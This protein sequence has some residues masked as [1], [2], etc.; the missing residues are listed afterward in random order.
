ML[1]LYGYCSTDVMEGRNEWECSCGAIYIPGITK[2]WELK[3]KK[4]KEKSNKENKVLDFI[5]ML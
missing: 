3:P 5:I 1:V 2:G 4:E